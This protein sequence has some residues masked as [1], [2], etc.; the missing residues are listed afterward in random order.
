MM[1]K[2]AIFNAMSPE[3]QALALR[4]VGISCD[5]DEY[6]EQDPSEVPVWSALEVSVPDTKRGPIANKR[7]IFKQIAREQAIAPKVDAYG[8]PVAG[9]QEEAMMM[10]GLV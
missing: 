4:A 10:S 5:E 3:N 2:S 8:M 7:E 1:N 6:G 9:E